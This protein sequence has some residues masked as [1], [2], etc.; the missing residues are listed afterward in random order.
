[1]GG[2]DKSDQLISYH[3]MTRQT[4]RYWKTIF[5]HLLEVAVTNA[6][7]MYKLFRIGDG[8][9]LPTESHFRD[10]LILQIIQKYGLPLPN[11]LVPSVQYRICHGSKPFPKEQRSRCAVCGTKTLRKC[12]DCPFTPALCQFSLHK[13]CHDVWHSTAHDSQRREWLVRKRACL[14]RCSNPEQLAST[15]ASSAS[16]KR[17]PGRPKGSK[18]KKKRKSY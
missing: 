5:Y 16:Q 15:S 3:R 2:V 14:A 6:F 18:D 1:M 7:I 11:G 4:K 10:Q 9:T 8:K 13:D 17:G 12:P